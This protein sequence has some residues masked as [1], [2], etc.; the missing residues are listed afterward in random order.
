MT[1]IEAGESFTAADLKPRR[2]GID[3]PITMLE[4]LDNEARR[5]GVTRQSLIKVWVAER[6]S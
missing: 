2:V 3:I 5:I 4:L 6:L 1:K